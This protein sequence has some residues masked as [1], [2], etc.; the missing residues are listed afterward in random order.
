MS[1]RIAKE[2][3]QAVPT[4]FKG[5]RYRS[6]SEAMFRVWLEM[7]CIRDRN[8]YGIIYEP[9]Y[10]TTDDGWT[11]D[12]LVWQAIHLDNKPEIRNFIY[13]YKPA[14]PTDAY[15]ELFL[16]RSKQILERFSS[17][18]GLHVVLMY[19]SVYE[20]DRG[21]VFGDSEISQKPQ[22]RTCNWIG[23]FEQAIRQ[24]RFD[25]EQRESR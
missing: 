1:V 22:L 9:D 23:E 12:F 20:Q 7:C 4:E 24:M 11:P 8:P 10:F 25:L 14:R 15:L 16:R 2:N 5:V 17:D 13:E 21:Y 18:R 6:K 3:L 19:G